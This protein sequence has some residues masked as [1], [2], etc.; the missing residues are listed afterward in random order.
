MV[1]ALMKK[2]ESMK[3]MCNVST[4]I[5]IILKKSKGHDGDQKHL[6]EMKNAFDGS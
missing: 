3:N 5:K 2:V 1:T 4:E 6:T